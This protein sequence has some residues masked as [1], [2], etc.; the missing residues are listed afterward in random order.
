MQRI[1]AR[2]GLSEDDRPWL[3]FVVKIVV[4]Y[5]IWKIFQ[6]TVDHTPA[7]LNIWNTWTT[8]Y[9]H[10]VSTACNKSL[11]LFGYEMNYHYRQ[12]VYIVGTEGFYVLEHCLAIPATL[13]FGAFIAVYQGPI[14]HKLWYIPLGMVGVQLINLL[15]LFLLA[16]LQKHAPARFFDF[17][18]SITA[19]VFQY[20]LVFLM[21]VF[22]M[23]RYYDMEPHSAGKTNLDPK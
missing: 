4:I 11:E 17:N 12:A 10:V 22:W 13:I 15:R 20:G 18:H 6:F 3:E 7:L 8:W 19:L 14:K 2:F 23:R 21:V 1:L 5:G 9:S 16:L